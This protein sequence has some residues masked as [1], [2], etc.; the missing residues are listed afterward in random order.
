M[1][2]LAEPVTAP[3]S[4]AWWAGYVDAARAEAALLTPRKRSPVSCPV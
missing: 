3:G 1:I 2:G 4:Q